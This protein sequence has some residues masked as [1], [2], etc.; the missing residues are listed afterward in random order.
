MINKIN[1]ALFISI[2]DLKCYILSYLSKKRIN[3]IALI[4]KLGKPYA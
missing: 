3:H 2:K 1:Q 4:K